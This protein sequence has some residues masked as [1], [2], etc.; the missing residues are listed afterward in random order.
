[1]ST[2]DPPW[3]GPRRARPG[4]SRR[5]RSGLLSAEV[6]M[7]RGRVAARLRGDLDVLSAG[8][9]AAAVTAAQ[10]QTRDAGVLFLLDGLGFSDSSGLG[11]FVGAFKRARAAGGSVALVTVPD[12]LVKTLRITGL[13]AY[14]PAFPTFEEAWEWLER[15]PDPAARRRRLES[16]RY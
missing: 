15:P 13:T 11:V 12:Y 1:M 4:Y 5:L 9:V 7:E 6:W 16:R 14:L 2:D 3:T 10:R 8:E